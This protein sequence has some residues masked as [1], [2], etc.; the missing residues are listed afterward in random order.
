MLRGA[1]AAWPACQQAPAGF[2]KHLGSR[3]DVGV[4][5]VLAPVMADA[6]DR[7]YEQH[8][9]RHDGGEDL[10]VVTGAARHPD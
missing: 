6:A 3:D 5:G 1:S 10:G 8:R 7:R 2:D 9:R 4:G